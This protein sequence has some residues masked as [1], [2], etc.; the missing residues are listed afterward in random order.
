MPTKRKIIMGNQNLTPLLTP[1]PPISVYKKIF[2]NLI[3][4]AILYVV[5]SSFEV[6][7]GCNPCIPTSVSTLSV[8]II[9]LVVS[10]LTIHTFGIIFA[11]TILPCGI[12][13]TDII[14][15]LERI[16]LWRTPDIFSWGV[17]ILIVFACVYSG[18]FPLSPFLINNLPPRITDFTVQFQNGRTIIVQSGRTIDIVSN[19]IIVVTANVPGSQTIT[20]DWLAINGHLGDAEGCATR[21]RPP[22]LINQDALTALAKTSCSDGTAFRGLSVNIVPYVP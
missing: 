19:E 11:G 3:S 15:F 6:F 21:Y 10:H 13:V 9:V 12:P 22:Q 4:L 8:S 17:A 14:E 7:K 2:F 16:H 1:P 5:L 18:F 20:C